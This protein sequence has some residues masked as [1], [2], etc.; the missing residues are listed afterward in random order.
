MAGSASPASAGPASAGPASAG[1]STGPGF[2]E[3]GEGQTPLTGARRPSSCASPRRHL[4]GHL[5]EPGRK[6][7]RRP[8]TTHPGIASFTVQD[9]EY[10]PKSSDVTSR[11]TSTGAVAVTSRRDGKA[12]GPCFL[13]SSFLFSYGQENRCQRPSVMNELYYYAISPHNRPLGARRWS[14]AVPLRSWGLTVSKP[15]ALLVREQPGRD[16]L[17]DGVKR[18]ILAAGS[19]QAWCSVT[20]PNSKQA[21]E[22]I[23]R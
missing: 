10:T 18:A 5:T 4:P 14:S 23:V 9:V 21:V 20:S 16:W 6:C 12:V 2:N 7:D 13:W 17:A 15:G 11:C 1:R 8:H 3:P 22:K 19:V